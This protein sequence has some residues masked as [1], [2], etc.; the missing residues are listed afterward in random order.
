MEVHGKA[1]WRWIS[2]REG[3]LVATAVFFGWGWVVCWVILFWVFW[4]HKSNPIL[5]SIGVLPMQR[6]PVPT[7]LCKGEPQLLRALRGGRLVG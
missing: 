3:Q 1:L 6:L 5:L 2:L 4:Q 7:G